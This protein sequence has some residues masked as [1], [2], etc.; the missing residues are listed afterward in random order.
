LCDRHLRSERTVHDK[1]EAFAAIEIVVARG[2]GLPEDI[3]NTEGGAIAHGHPIGA[4][5][6]DTNAHLW[7]AAAGF[8]K[9]LVSRD[10]EAVAL[11]RRAIETNRN[12]SLAHFWLAAAHA[13]R[14][15]SPG[16]SQRLGG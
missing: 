9:L 2:L 15:A 8:A 14:G 13:H 11:L 1:G 5:P 12:Y 16:F 6:R 10:E 7:L 4:T 3:V